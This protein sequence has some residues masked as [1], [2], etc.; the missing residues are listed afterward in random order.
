MLTN[1]YDGE[2]V[3]RVIVNNAEYIIV[4]NVVVQKHITWHES[5]ILASKVDNII[6]SPQL[7][8]PI[9]N[10]NPGKEEAIYKIY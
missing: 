7:L 1:N 6:T 10:M 5:R 8:T 3:N 2:A 9:Y 4:D